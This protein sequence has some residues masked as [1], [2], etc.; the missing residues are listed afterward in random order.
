MLITSPME[1]WE[2]VNL[3]DARHCVGNEIK[4]PGWRQCAEFNRARPFKNLCN[5]RWDYRARRLAGAIS[6]EWPG[7]RHRSAERTKERQ[8]DLISPDLG[9]SIGRLPDQRMPSVIGTNWAVPYTSLVEVTVSLLNSRSRAAC[10]MFK[11]PRTLTS[12]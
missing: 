9:R 10:A 3:N 4:I 6:I 1:F 2:F 8:R 11:V 7:Y 12:T 5:C